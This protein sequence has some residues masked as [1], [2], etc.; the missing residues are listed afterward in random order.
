M[1]KWTKEQQKLIDIGRRE[2]KEKVVGIIEKWASKADKQYPK[3]DGLI[4]NWREDLLKKIE[5]KKED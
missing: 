3:F 1:N 2:F 5:S 4:W